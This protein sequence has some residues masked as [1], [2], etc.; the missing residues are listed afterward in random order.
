MRVAGIQLGVISRQ[1]SVILNLPFSEDILDDSKYHHTV[2]VAQGTPQFVDNTLF[3]DGNTALSIPSNGTPFSFG[4]GDFTIE[5]FVKLNGS[6]DRSYVFQRLLREYF[7]I[8]TDGS[9]QVSVPL[10]TGALSFNIAAGTFALNTRYHFAFVR[11][12]LTFKGYV[13]GNL[14]GSDT[15]TVLYPHAA[16]SQS[17]SIGAYFNG[18]GY[19]NRLNGY[20]DKYKITK[21]ALYT[22]NF[23]PP[24]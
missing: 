16:G 15:E 24:V 1:D 9:G 18:S 11:E 5:G 4:T 8:H 3:L 22:S 10:Q 20:L 21:K 12:G 7:Y 19:T 13:A 17:L 14:V 2:N 6:T 23:T